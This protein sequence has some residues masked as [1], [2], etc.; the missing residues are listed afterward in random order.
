MHEVADDAQLSSTG[1]ASYKGRAAPHVFVEQSHE[2][3]MGALT[4]V[5]AS[6]ESRGV[7]ASSTDSSLAVIISKF[8]L[9]L[10][11]STTIAV[12]QF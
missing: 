10:K 11:S 8:S 6:R 9:K 7:L 12:L 3:D 5:E 1:S 4:R 2:N